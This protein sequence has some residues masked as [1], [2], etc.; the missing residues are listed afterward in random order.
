MCVDKLKKK[1]INLRIFIWLGFLNSHWKDWCWSWSSNTLASW[2]E[3]LTPY[4]MLGKIKAGREGDGRGWDGW[5]ASLTGYTW[6]WA[7]SRGWWWTG[8]PGVLPSRA[9]QS[10]TQLCDWTEL[11]WWHWFSNSASHNHF[12]L[13]NVGAEAYVSWDVS[14]VLSLF[15]LEL[16]FLS[17]LHTW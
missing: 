8:K 2:C 1:T 6:V 7:S 11:N 9:L 14:F 12:K 15:Q 5:M 16:W 13:W 4:L 3:E 17:I 10:Q